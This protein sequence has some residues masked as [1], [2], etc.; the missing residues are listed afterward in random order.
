MVVIDHRPDAAVLVLLWGRPPRVLMERKSCTLPGRFSCDVA[1][2]G[3]RI[4][5]GETPAETALREAW[6]EAWIPPRSVKVVESL[7]LFTTRSEPVICTEALLG[8]VAG[9]V[10]PMPRDPEVDAVFWI[11]LHRLPQPSTVVHRR[12]GA[13]RGIAI[14][15]DLILWGMTLRIVEALRSKLQDL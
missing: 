8:R 3:G 1:F 9:P 14:S 15:D 10:D 11:D 4:A 6:E 2:P 13:V 7:G 5:E 12:R